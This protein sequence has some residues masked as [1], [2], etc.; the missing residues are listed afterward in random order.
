LNPFEDGVCIELGSRKN[1]IT[2][3][4]TGNILTTARSLSFWR[5]TYVLM[6]AKDV[7]IVLM[8]GFMVCLKEILESR[9]AALASGAHGGC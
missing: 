6:M 1:K 2:N 4:E 7:D 5:S 8:T 3:K 9:S